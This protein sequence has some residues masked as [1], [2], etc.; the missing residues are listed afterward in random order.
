[1]I[2]LVT[3]SI[4]NSRDQKWRYYPA[5]SYSGTI[6]RDKL[7]ERISESTTFTHADVLTALCAFE[8]A[9]AEKL[10]SGGMVKLGSLGSF[11]TTLRSSGGEVNKDD[12]SAKHIRSLHVAFLPQA[13]STS[14]CRSKH[15][16]QCR[17]RRALRCASYLS[18]MGFRLLGEGFSTSR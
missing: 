14:N 5:I 10:Q 8:E 4:K 6:T 2:K 7:C 13:R 9:I 17:K 12:V 15:S 1:M 16:T 3:R 11:R 18:V